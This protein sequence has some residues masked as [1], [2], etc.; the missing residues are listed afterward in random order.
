MEIN[1]TQA[2]QIY[3]TFDS[4]SNIYETMSARELQQEA[5]KHNT[6]KDLLDALFQIESDAVKQQR[7]DEPN[8]FGLAVDEAWLEDLRK[9]LDELEIELGTENN[10][11]I[12][13]ES[14]VKDEDEEEDNAL[15]EEGS[16]LDDLIFAVEIDEDEQRFW[17]TGKKYWQENQCVDDRGI[18]IP[19]DGFDEMS[20]GMFEYDG[21][22]EEGKQ[23]LL[24]AGLT[25][26]KDFQ[27]F[28]E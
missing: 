11:S 25:S 20:E 15:D 1:L 9:E 8:M 7:Q 10:E 13:S 24:D 17:I 18:S 4:D 21:S 6:P 14:E 3:H 16:A 22:M 26:P 28:I 23:K 2:Y 12:S 19:I 27:E 5:Q